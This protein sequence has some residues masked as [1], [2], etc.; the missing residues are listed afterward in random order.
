[1]WGEDETRKSNIGRFKY[2]GI[3]GEFCREYSKYILYAYILLKLP[4]YILWEYPSIYHAG[5]GM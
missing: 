1:M 4:R 2:D 3:K 5:T